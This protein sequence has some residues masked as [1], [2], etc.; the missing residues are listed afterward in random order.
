MMTATRTFKVGSELMKGSDVKAWQE[1]IDKEFK[2]LKINCPI[3]HDGVYGVNTRSY[4][5]A[6]LRAR[7]ISLRL[8]DAGV[9]PSLRSK[10]RN[11]DLNTTETKRFHAKTTQEYRAK[12]KKQWAPA[13]VHQPVT[14]ILA[15][16]WGYHPGIHDGV[17]VI[18]NPNAAV[19]AMVKCKVIDVRAFGWWGLGAQPS[20]GHP[21]SDGDGIVQV[22]VLES[23][24]PFKKGHHIGYG[25]CEHARV[26]VG[27]VLQA[28]EVIALAGFARAWHIHLMYNN[29]STSKGIG[30]IDPRPILDYSVKHG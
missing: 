30:N 15:D 19:Y 28:G 17:D 4:S 3:K 7:G 5:A 27:E 24:G 13:K 20:I 9:T 23:V 10:I 8:M 16:S 22:E 2:H 25:H 12:L 11:R 1:L 6:L 29:G 14:K 21:V 26:K 18:C